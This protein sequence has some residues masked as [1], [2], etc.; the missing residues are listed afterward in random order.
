MSKGSLEIENYPYREVSKIN[1]NREGV[2]S[3][4]NIQDEGEFRKN[5]LMKN[6]LDP[7]LVENLEFVSEYDVHYED[8]LGD[9]IFYQVSWFRGFIKINGEVYKLYI[10]INSI[11]FP[12]YGRA[13]GDEDEDNSLFQDTNSDEN[14]LIP[15][16]IFMFIFDDYGSREMDNKKLRKV[17]N[18][19]FK[20]GI[21]YIENSVKNGKH[22][23]IDD[24]N[25]N[26]FSE[27]VLLKY[28]RNKNQDFDVIELAR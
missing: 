3:G 7:D 11:G 16:V 13:T 20:H 17:E 25:K 2:K 21:N 12:D 28:V 10:Q 23:R 4:Y 5:L 15:Y 22:T 18:F 27:D 14:G 19:L 8:D 9:E 6:G 24:G 26:V 1:F